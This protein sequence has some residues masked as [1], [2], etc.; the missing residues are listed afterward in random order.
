[1]ST[2]TC[3]VSVSEMLPLT[4]YFSG[5]EHYVAASFRSMELVPLKG[6]LVLHEEHSAV[7]EE[8]L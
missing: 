8:L 2:S 4:D 7:V 1:M 5:V 3:V 6:N